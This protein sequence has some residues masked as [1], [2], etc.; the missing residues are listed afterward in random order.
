MEKPTPV[1]FFVFCLLVLLLLSG[2]SP[3]DNDPL[4][5][6][7][8]IL[9]QG[10]FTEDAITEA[11]DLLPEVRASGDSRL[12]V[13]LLLWL[14]S[15]YT[16]IGEYER[17]MEFCTEAATAASDIR[18]S[19]RMAKAELSIGNVQY[20]A[21]NYERSIRTYRPLVA[22][23]KGLSDTLQAG[24]VEANIALNYL[25]QGKL[26]SALQQLLVARGTILTY[27]N[28]SDLLVIDQNIGALY[29]QKGRPEQGLPYI[30]QCLATILAKRDT[31]TFAPAYGNL[32]YTFQQ[33]GNF[34]RAKIYYD[35]SLYYSRLLK[36][37]ATTYVTL[38]DM[39]DGYQQIG[40]YKSALKSFQEYHDVQASVLNESTLSRI[41]ELEVKHES[42]RKRLA[43]KSSE[44]KVLALEQK[45]RIRNNRQLLIA[46]GLVASLLVALLTF[47]QWRKDIR[48][49]ETK[50]R[51]I[52][53]ELENE[54]LASGQ[55]STR[56]ENQKEDLTDFAL[57]I[58]RKNKFS[59]EL[60]DRLD[61]LKKELPAQF[62]PQLNELVRF[63]QDH[64]RLNENLEIVQENIDQVNHEFHRKLQEAFP[65]LT[66][67]D[68]SL[69]GMIRLNMTNKEVATNRGISTASAKMARYRLRK[70]L[71]L[72]STDDIHTFLREF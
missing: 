50:G 63:A 10:K 8:D 19:R 59:R 53:A 68:R 51:L 58:E 36:Q 71:K 6:R 45:A 64:D 1:K 37:D 7:V 42:E 62:R 2:M 60:A 11:N 5:D 35:S 13:D 61:M 29:S 24:K 39:S 57:D 55:L 65:N 47:L 52:E 46:G 4:R 72:K 34:D 27:G 16:R 32:A 12:V 44:Q 3:F 43:L 21:G 14:S 18:D 9:Q 30:E 20:G 69:A 49:R 41:V 70:K 40:D 48:L 54:R 26:D 28:R 17:S 33:L 31:F 38:K 25:S 66:S 67:S 22:I 23:Y 15:Y 56:L